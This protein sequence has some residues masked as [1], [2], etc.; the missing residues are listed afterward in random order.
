MATDV[1]GSLE[2]LGGSKIEIYDANYDN[3]E[4]GQDDFLQV[5]LAN[6]KYQDPFET[7]DISKFIDNTVKLRELEIMNN[8]ENSVKALNDNNTL[9]LNSANLIDKNIVYK[10]D[11][12]YIEDGKAY[13]EFSVKEN[14]DEAE[15][16]IYD[17][18]GQKIAEESFRDL[19]VG[20]KYTFELENIEVED[21]YYNVSVVANNQNSSVEADVYSS[22]KVSGIEK[23]INDILVIV[24]NKRVK[25]SDIT[26]IGG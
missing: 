12:L 20:K 11:R 15:V 2:G 17:D 26:K 22:A 16:Y 19:K 7:Q 24:D 23:D 1:I 4:M 9:F 25:I 21:G 3:A 18:N 6:F 14:A 13:V 5:L 8:F 10:G